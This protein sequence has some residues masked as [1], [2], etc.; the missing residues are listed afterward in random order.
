MA[1]IAEQCHYLLPLQF[2]SISNVGIIRDINKRS[3]S[4]NNAHNLTE[5]YD[6]EWINFTV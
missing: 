6:R 3:V 1:V 5:K 2:M 4:S